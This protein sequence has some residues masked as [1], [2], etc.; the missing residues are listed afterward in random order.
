[1]LAEVSSEEGKDRGREI[2]RNRRERGTMKRE[3]RKK[4][5]G[6]GEKRQEV[7]ERGEKL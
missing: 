3:E 4:G 6:E 7:C 1:M 5:G 2:K